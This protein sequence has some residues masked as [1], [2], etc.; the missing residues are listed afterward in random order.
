MSQWQKNTA[1]DSSVCPLLVRVRG[2]HCSSV[3]SHHRCDGQ[4]RAC[5]LLLPSVP[6]ASLRSQEPSPSSWPHS[7]QA[8][9][10]RRSRSD[11]GPPRCSR[12]RPLHTACTTQASVNQG[13]NNAG[14]SLRQPST[15]RPD[16]ALGGYK[17]VAR[18]DFPLR[19]LMAT[20]ESR[21]TVLLSF[22][23]TSPPPPSSWELRN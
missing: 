9:T 14:V 16:Q 17:R 18:M 4:S 5:L 20:K 10:H 23:G 3:Q 19:G 8:P 6:A 12:E 11:S 1:L 21:P 13:N 7:A 15:H 22:I 2:D